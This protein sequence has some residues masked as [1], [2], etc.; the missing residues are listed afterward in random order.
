MASLLLGQYGDRGKK[1]GHPERVNMQ[2]YLSCSATTTKVRLQDKLQVHFKLFGKVS[3][4][5]SS[6]T[7]TIGYHLHLLRL[8]SHPL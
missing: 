8:V 1:R 3:S 5:L 4:S 6:L 7:R 2:F